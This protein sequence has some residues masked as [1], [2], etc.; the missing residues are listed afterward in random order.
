[1]AGRGPA[2]KEDPIRRN[3][4][5]IDQ[6]VVVEDQKLR[7]MPLPVFEVTNQYGEV[8]IFKWHSRTVEWWNKTR[9]SP[10]AKVMAES[11][12]EA[13]VETAMIHTRFYNGGLKP[14]EFTNLAAELRRRMAAHGA[15]YED[16]LRLRMV[17]ETDQ[18]ELEVEQEI[19]QAAAKAVNY[20]ERLTKAATE[21]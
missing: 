13:M 9:R 6:T 12:W 21:E 1:M 20:M 18:S 4:P 8:E 3:K 17:I 7:G 10:Q 19:K 14:T 15:T 11:D 2:P 5:T 16:R